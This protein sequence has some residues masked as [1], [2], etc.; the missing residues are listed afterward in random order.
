MLA[1]QQRKWKLAAR[2]VL[3]DSGKELMESGAFHNGWL[4]ASRRICR[5]LLRPIVGG[6]ALWLC[7]VPPV[8]AACGQAVDRPRVGLVLSGGGALGASHVGVLKVL[9]ELRVPIDCIAGTSMGAI[10]GGLYASGMN[11]EILERT[12]KELDWEKIFADRPP[13]R[14]RDFR[15]KIEDE[16]ISLPY[17]I[18]VG[19]DSPSLPRGLILGQQLT[20]ALRALALNAVTIPSFDLLPIPFRAIA[21]DIE[22]G[23]T[24]VL[25]RGDLPSAM[26]ASMAVSGVFPP[27][28]LDGRLLVDGGLSNNLPVDVVRSMGADILI[29]ADIPSQLNKRKDLNS[30]G[31]I[32]GQSVSLMILR[33]SQAQIASLSASDILLKPDLTGLDATSFERIVEMVPRGAEGARAQEPKLRRLS[34]PQAQYTAHVASRGVLKSIARTISNIRLENRSRVADAVILSR[35]TFKAGDTLDIPRLEQDISKIYGLDYFETVTYR[36]EEQQSGVDLIIVAEESTVGLATLRAGVN[37]Q[38]DLSN[39]SQYTLGGQLRLSNLNSLGAEALIDGSF[40]SSNT[41]SVAYLHPLDAATRYYISPILRLSDVEVGQFQRGDRVRELRDQRI[42]AGLGFS[43]QIA[44]WGVASLRGEYGFARQ[45]LRSGLPLLGDRDFSIARYVAEFRYDTVD[46]VY[47]PKDGE[48]LRLRFID[49]L[50]GLNGDDDEM[51]ASLIGSTTHTWGRNTLRFQVAGGTTIDPSGRSRNQFPLG[52]FLRLSGYP[53][54]E[55]GGDHFGLVSII[56]VHD[57]AKKTPLINLPI[58]VGASVEAGAAWNNG[59]GK[60][61]LRLSGS[62]FAGADT[63]VGPIYLAYGVG[64]ID[65]HALYFILGQPF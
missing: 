62:V 31:A 7:A 19:G 12:L 59:G 10:V 11:A 52:G 65:R 48:L 5:S 21:A 20:L 49:N 63:P 25:D 24:V 18:G 34:L 61:P 32:I 30:I 17:R 23:E 38:Y 1:F 28:E 45:E 15:R 42:F 56:G 60:G 14:E 54:G 41:L 8:Q 43:R 22:T 57:F 50:G 16:G 33:S 6:L 29:V 3:A 40:G 58:V 46:D 51:Q 44:N 4:Q 27:V 37:L 39:G 13:R 36:I 64:G 35:L 47:F 55:L 53:Y 26:R 2:S 9:E